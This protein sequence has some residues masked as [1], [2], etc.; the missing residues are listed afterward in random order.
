M[1]TPL[2]FSAR[3]RWH[4][5]L[6][7]LAFGCLLALTFALTAF[8]QSTTTGLITGRVLNPATGEYIRNIEVRIEGTQQ[9]A[10][11]EEGGY[12]RLT[13]APAGET[14]IVASY[15]GHQSATAHLTVTAGTTSTHDFELA[16]VGSG[17][18]AKVGPDDAIKLSEFVVSSERE[19]Q[20]KAISEQ[21][22]SMNVKTVVASDNFGDIAEGNIGEFLKFM[23]GV[24]L[25]YVETDTRAAR[26]SGMEARYGYVTING[27]TIANTSTG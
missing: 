9:V 24:T 27:N 18:N 7:Q 4:A 19:G 5:S 21:K 20:A 3:A 26:M 17:G 1:T 12:Y 25:D 14:T 2:D 13:D 22:Q 16:P 6:Y 15:T 8:A 23:P 11:S 10:I